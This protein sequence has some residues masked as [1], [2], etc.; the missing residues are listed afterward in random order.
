MIPI[1]RPLI[2][3]EEIAAVVDVLRS[4]QLAQGPKVA[5]FEAAFAQF[6]R[7]KHA[8]A[9]SSGTTALQVALLA[10]GIGDG[11]EVVTS[12]FSFVASAN[13]VLAV[14]AKP[15]FADIEPEYYTINPN[16]IRE[17]LSP[18]TRALIVVHLYGQAC[19]MDEI[20]QI[21]EER[22][23]ALIEDAC[24]AHGA[25]Y[26]GKVVGAHGTACYSFYPTKNMTTAEG[27]MITTNRDDIAE[28]ARMLRNHGG[29]E[30]YSHEILGYNFRMTE[31]QAAIG[32]VQLGKL[33]GWNE[34]RR[35]NALRLTQGLSHIPG[36]TT[37]EIRPDAKHVFHQYTIRVKHRDLLIESLKE[38][39][40]GFGIHYPQ[41]IY[42]Q[43]LY[44]SLGYKD[45][46]KYT[47][48]ATREVLSLPVYASLHQEDLDRIIETVKTAQPVAI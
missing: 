18:S 10:H 28:Q 47:E 27:G 35:E 15:V 30:R 7:V 33:P 34:G 1:A 37:P 32:L 22:N 48:Q 46:L 29:R 40:I 13:T 41:P 24:Q 17:K 16:D 11:N 8:I 38:N 31:I 25:E 39:G 5:E 44:K 14:G 3:E 26:K 42:T 23:L 2:G 19:E 36:I 43:P 9:T 12:A 20:A 21:A 4:G 6:C 45:Q